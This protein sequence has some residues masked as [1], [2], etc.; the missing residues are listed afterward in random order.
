MGPSATSKICSTIS[1]AVLDEALSDCSA[2]AAETGL[3][4]LA[5]LWQDLQ[6]NK[7][8]HDSLTQRQHDSSTAAAEMAEHAQ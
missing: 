1:I 7:H 6:K 2:A 3:V 8:T 4:A 5:A